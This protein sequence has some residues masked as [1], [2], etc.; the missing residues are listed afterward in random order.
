M[1]TYATTGAITLSWR[2]A[3][4]AQDTPANQDASPLLTF[5]VCRREGPDDELELV[6]RAGNTQSSQPEHTLTTDVQRGIV[7]AAFLLAVLLDGKAKVDKK[8]VDLRT[9][10]QM[11]WDSQPATSATPFKSSPT[12]TGPTRRKDQAV[13]RATTTTRHC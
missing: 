3:H 13:P 5:V 4:A 7:R 2:T 10:L 9:D 6:S 11:W 12:G 8:E 1:T